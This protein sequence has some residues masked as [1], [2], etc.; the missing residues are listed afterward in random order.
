MKNNDFTF[1][2]LLILLLIQ[3]LIIENPSLKEKLLV[4]GGKKN[5]D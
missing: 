5:N 3:T 4:M 1:Q 2:E